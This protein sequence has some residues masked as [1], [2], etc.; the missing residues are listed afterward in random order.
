MRNDPWDDLHNSWTVEI[1]Q[2]RKGGQG[3]QQ[4]QNQN[5]SQQQSGSVSASRRLMG[6]GCQVVAAVHKRKVTENDDAQKKIG[7]LCCCFR[8]DG[9]RAYLEVGVDA[10]SLNG[11]RLPV[12]NIRLPAY[13]VVETTADDFAMLLTV[14]EDPMWVPNVGQMPVLAGVL[15]AACALSFEAHR[16]W[17]EDILERLWPADYELLRTPTFW[18]AI[19]AS[20]AAHVEVQEDSRADADLDELPRADLLSLLFAREQLALAWAEIA[21]RAPTDFVCTNCT[22]GTQTQIGRRSR[23]GRIIRSSFPDD[24]PISDCASA[25]ADR[26]H[27]RWA[28]LVHTTG[29]YVRRMNDPLMGLQDLRAIPWEVEGFCDKCV[30]AGTKTWDKFRRSLWDDLDVWLPL[31]DA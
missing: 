25:N 23:S 2:S 18:Q 30:A 27:A 3:T 22:P 24:D 17:A 7:I 8:K 19:T 14:I 20:P 5:H 12:Y 31:A 4:N 13:R 29:L 15:R 1:S 16:K 21:G 11:D 9:G 10:Q 6:A 26:V 28:E